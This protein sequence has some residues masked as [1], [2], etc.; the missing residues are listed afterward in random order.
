MRNGDGDLLRADVQR[1]NLLIG[2]SDLEILLDLLGANVGR[3]TVL[4]ES[5]YLL[6][7]RPTEDEGPRKAGTNSNVFLMTSPLADTPPT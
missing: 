3:L 1:P 7:H 2:T 4:A 6:P 5:L